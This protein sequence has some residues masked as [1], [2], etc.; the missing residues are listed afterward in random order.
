MYERKMSIYN[1]TK[2]GKK[3]LCHD[4][5]NEFNVT[6]LKNYGVFLPPSWGLL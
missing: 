6:L 4:P 3:T 5:K 1:I 2:L